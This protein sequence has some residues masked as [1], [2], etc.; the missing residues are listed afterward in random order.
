VVSSDAST[1]AQ[2]L[3]ELPPDR[4]DDVAAVRD[5]VNGCLPDEVVEVMR[6]GMLAWEVPLE[7]SGQTSSGRPVDVVALAAQ[8]RKN[9]LY[10]STLNVDA[11][12]SAVFDAAWRATGLPLDRGKACVRFRSLE[13]VPMDV[14]EA[15]LRAIDVDD[16]VARAVDP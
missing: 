10:V 6:Y 12:A 5:L 14:L 9:S 8:K 4:R 2:F 16:L 3:A 7:V 13:H 1:P 11:E 15:T